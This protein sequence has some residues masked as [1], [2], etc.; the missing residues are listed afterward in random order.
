M[1]LKV[2]KSNQPYHFILIPIIAFA[3]WV[4]PLMMPAAYPFFSGEDSMIL[5]KPLR[6]LLSDNLTLSSL[7]AFT[8]TL[9]LSFLILK[10]N[11]QYTFIRIKSFLPSSL[12]ILVTS[13]VADLHFMHPIYPATLFLVIAID[14][15]FDSYEKDVIHS[16]AFDAGI[17]LAIGSLFYLNLAF[18]F[19]LIWFGF[20]IVKP[21]VNWREYILSTI[22]FIM[23]WL[24]AFAYYMAIGAQDE[25]R[26]TLMANFTAHQ[27]FLKGNLVN[28]IYAVYLGLLILM[29]SYYLLS[30]Y[31][32]KRISSRKFFKV[33]FWVFVI[34]ALLMAFHPA[35]S[36]EIII[37]MAIPLAYLISNY[38]IFMKHQLW[39]EVL[40]FLLTAA[41]IYLQLA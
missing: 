35:V 40:L 39:G 24:A 30:S 16:N 32:D 8:F 9:L 6:Y 3:L 7:L 12:F 25:L 1:L 4:K 18:F 38:F 17:F 31:D 23:P 19:P 5:Y 34:S 10:L 15:I 13:G 26:Q 22:G 29:G 2:L 41:V 37:V 14:R 36:K 20:I 27:S 21:N 33:F 28:Q 11:V